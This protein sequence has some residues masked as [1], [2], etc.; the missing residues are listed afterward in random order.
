M[1]MPEFI[2]FGIAPDDPAV[3]TQAFMDIICTVIHWAVG[4][5]VLGGAQALIL[6]SSPV[7]PGR[8]VLATFAGF[9]AAALV[10]ACPLQAVGILGRIPGPVEPILFTVGGLHWCRRPP[11]L[12]SAPTT[13]FGWQMVASLDCRLGSQLGSNGACILRLAGFAWSGT[14]MA[15]RSVSQWV[16]VCGRGGLGERQGTFLCSYAGINPDDP[17]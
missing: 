8:W 3:P 13:R 11:K 15:S 16:H 12:P 14:D 9:A 17:R 7:R 2:E 4:G 1:L 10:I 5:T 6:R